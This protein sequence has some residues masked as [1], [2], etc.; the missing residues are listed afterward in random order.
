MIIGMEKSKISYEYCSM[1]ITEYY[2][3]HYKGIRG[4][5]LY[6]KIGFPLE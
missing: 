6:C 1:E 4:K 2:D 5:C 3:D